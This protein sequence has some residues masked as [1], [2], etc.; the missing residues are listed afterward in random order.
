MKQR[1]FEK[2][3]WQLLSTQAF[4]V[5]LKDYE[6]TFAKLLAIMLG[7]EIGWPSIVKLEDMLDINLRNRQKCLAL[8]LTLFPMVSKKQNNRI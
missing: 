1:L 3:T 8:T 2:L 7:P 6:K 4:T 5:S